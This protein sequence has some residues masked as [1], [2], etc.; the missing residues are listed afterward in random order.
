[1]KAYSPD[2]R[3]R[4][5]RALDGGMSTSEAARVF[6]VGI[7]T[8]KR[9]VRQ[10][11]ETGSLAPKPIPGRPARIGPAEHAALQAQLESHPTETL[12]RHCEL[13]EQQHGTRVSIAT[14]S[15]V[16]RRL[17]WVHRDGRWVRASLAKRTRRHG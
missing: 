11:R 12:A 3:E 2:L 9:Y 5:L 16:I 15:R 4:I 8:V 1:M 14:M 6:D 13:W 7:S 10:Q 17:G